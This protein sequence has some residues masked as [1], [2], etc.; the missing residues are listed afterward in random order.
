M[1]S[2][3][4]DAGGDVGFVS[5]PGFGSMSPQEVIFLLPLDWVGQVSRGG[6][7]AL[8]GSSLMVLAVR[9]SDAMLDFFGPVLLVQRYSG[10]SHIRTRWVR[11]RRQRIRDGW[12]RN[13]RQRIDKGIKCL[14]R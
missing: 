14:E 8:S 2:V 9:L 10:G 3:I 11:N 1:V 13:R 12:V 5:G 6:E 4:G 7:V